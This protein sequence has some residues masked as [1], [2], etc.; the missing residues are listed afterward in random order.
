MMGE[1][2]DEIN[3]PMDDGGPGIEKQDKNRFAIRIEMHN[4]A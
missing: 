4:D 2:D 1:D 3:A